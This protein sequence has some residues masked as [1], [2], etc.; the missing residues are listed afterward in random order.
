MCYIIVSNPKNALEE[1]KRHHYTKNSP[2]SNES[3]HS[4]LEVILL[5]AAF[6]TEHYHI[7]REIVENFLYSEPEHDQ[8]Y[9]RAKLIMALLMDYEANGATGMESILKRKEALIEIVDCIDVAMLPE[10]IPRYNFLVFNASVICWM[11]VHKFLRPGFAKHF[12][13][14]IKKV[15]DSL[16]QLQ[17]ADIDWRIMYSSAAAL[18]LEDDK[19]PKQAGEM[20]DQA[21]EYAEIYVNESTAQEDSIHDELKAISKESDEILSSLRKLQETSKNPGK[22]ARGAGKKPNVSSSSHPKHTPDSGNNEMSQKMKEMTLQFDA[23][24]K[25][26]IKT[27]L[28]LKEIRDIKAPQVESLTRL[29]MQR[30]QVNTSEAKKASGNSIVSKILRPNVLMQLQQMVSGKDRMS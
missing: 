29:Y 7:A 6:A 24:Q 12:L 22:D 21:I 20:V 13:P 16:E 3:I 23:L 11:V 27:N 14:E 17:D 18:C 4:E 5:E 26:R 25:K 9:C 1:Y 30:I 28:K 2:T 15:F 8:Y 19:Q 10:N